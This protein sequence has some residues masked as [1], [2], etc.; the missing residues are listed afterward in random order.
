MLERFETL[1]YDGCFL[2][3]FDSKTPLDGWCMAVG[4]LINDEEGFY[5]RTFTKEQWENVKTL[6]NEEIFEK[7][8]VA[9]EAPV[10]DRT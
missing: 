6:T 8:P 5:W 1:M 9:P 2:S 7:Y 4:D 10:L 3:S